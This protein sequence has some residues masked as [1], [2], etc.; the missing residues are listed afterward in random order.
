[1]EKAAFRENV[2][3]IQRNMTNEPKHIVEANSESSKKSQMELFTKSFI[4]DVWI[5]CEYTSVQCTN[6][7]EKHSPDSKFK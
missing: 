4:L 7:L 5:S 3:C 6:A 1:M 2:A